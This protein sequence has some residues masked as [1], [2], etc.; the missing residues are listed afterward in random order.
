M[1]ELKVLIYLGNHIN[2]VN[3]LGA[4]T[5]GG[6]QVCEIISGVQIFVYPAEI[7]AFLLISN[8]QILSNS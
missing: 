3:L 8:I 6:M 5:V 1:S 7:L 2:I 4:C